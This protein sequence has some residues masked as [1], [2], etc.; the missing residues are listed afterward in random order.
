LAN[1]FLWQ[2]DSVGLSVADSAAAPAPVTAESIFACDLLSK[3]PSNLIE[4][5]YTRN[6]SDNRQRGF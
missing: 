3:E 2:A 6:P 5:N 1:R 4:R